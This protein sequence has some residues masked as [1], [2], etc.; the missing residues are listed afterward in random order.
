METSNT[1]KKKTKGGLIVSMI[2][3]VLAIVACVTGLF[4]ADTLSRPAKEAHI[5]VNLL[6][7]VMILVYSF[8]GYKTPHGN[9]LRTIMFVFGILV[10]ARIVLPTRPVDNE[11]I[12]KITSGC[13]GLAA[14]LIAFIS[15]RL[16][17]YEQNRILMVI[18]GIL[19]LAPVVMTL[20]SFSSFVL[21][22][23]ISV[24]TMLFCWAAIGFAY[25]ARYEGHKLAGSEV[26]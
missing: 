19:L 6:T 4:N 5:I 11:V 17:R 2:L 20:L 12:K 16:D 24:S 22:R 15:G 26:V 10:L 1:L 18:V 9:M 25:T 14:M 23:C 21:M 7:A 8:W 13:F 3:T